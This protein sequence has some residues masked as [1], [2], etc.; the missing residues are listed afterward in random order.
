MLF[1]QFLLSIGKTKI[2]ILFALAALLQI[3]LILLFHGSLLTVIQMSII[4]A[5]LLDIALLVYFVLK[6]K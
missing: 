3:G 4:S 6:V 1:T 2:I 5:S